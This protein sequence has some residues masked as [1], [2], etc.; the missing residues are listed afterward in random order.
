MPVLQTKLIRFVNRRHAGP[1]VDRMP[2]HASIP[3][4]RSVVL[5][6][7]LSVLAACGGGP[8][9]ATGTDALPGAS[10]VGATPPPDIASGRGCDNPSPT[11]REKHGLEVDGL[12]RGGQPFYALF[13]GVTQLRS[14]DPLTTYLRMPGARVPRITLVS[15]DDHLVRVGGLRPGLSP[16]SWDRPGDPWVATLTFSR[17]GCWRVYVDRS[18]FDGEIWVHVR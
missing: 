15:A 4:R 12:M 18:G 7:A 2:R 14:G 6:A 8:T 3:W 5:V 1:I 17:A 16:F 13:E 10:S 11:S 9:I